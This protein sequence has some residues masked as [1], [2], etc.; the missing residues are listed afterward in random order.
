MKAEYDF[1]KGKRGAVLPQKGKTRISIFIDNAV[2]DEFRGRAEKAG[3]GYQTMMNDALRKHLAEA[4]QP[5]SEDKIRQILRQEMPEYLRGL[6]IKSAPTEMDAVYVQTLKNMEA[7]LMGLEKHV[8]APKRVAY[9]D[10]FVYRYSERSIHQAI[11]QKLGRIVSGL[12]AARILLEH[13]FVQ[14]QGALQRMLDEFEEDVTFLGLAVIYDHKTELHQ[15]YLDAFY[16]EEFDKPSDP[17]ASTQRRPMIPRDKIRAYIATS[18][19]AAGLDSHRGIQV[20]RT[21]S[22]GYS[23]Y[24]HGASPHIMEM[25]GGNPPRF[26]VSG[27]LGTPR[28]EGHSQDLWNYFYRGIIAFA[29][30]AKAFGD[31]ALFESIRRYRDDFETQANKDHGAADNA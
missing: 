16:Q 29:L 11:L 24:V 23:G 31:D 18:E 10:A 22:K 19:A 3:I 2:L 14:E 26:H 1:S 27:M 13:G 5:V 7:T 12:H 28:I 25:Y 30:A 15:R 9:K 21:L 8:P 20:G 17:V 6:S 4:I